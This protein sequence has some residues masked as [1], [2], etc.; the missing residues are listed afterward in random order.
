MDDGSCGQKRTRGEG[1]GSIFTV[2]LRT[3]FMDDPYAV[4]WLSRYIGLQKAVKVRSVRP[5]ALLAND[6]HY[7]VPQ[8]CRR[9][10]R[11]DNY[12]APHLNSHRHVGQA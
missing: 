12:S 9:A 2:F 6:S 5:I 8:C 7:V 10:N 3:F 11:V 1:R 4:V